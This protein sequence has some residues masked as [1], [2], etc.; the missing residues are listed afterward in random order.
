MVSSY[1]YLGVRID[2]C[3]QLKLEREEKRKREAALKKAS[4]IIDQKKLPQ[5][6]R[7]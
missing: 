7:Y 4:W 1:S 3:G 5:M 6:G 2:N